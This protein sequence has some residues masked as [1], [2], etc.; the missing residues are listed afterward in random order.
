MHFSFIIPAG[1]YHMMGVDIKEMK[2]RYRIFSYIYLSLFG[3][4]FSRM[5]VSTF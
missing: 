4:K 2:S 5:H 3:F 1:C